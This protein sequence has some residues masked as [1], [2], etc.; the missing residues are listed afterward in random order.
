MID[1]T[2]Q[3]PT[4]QCGREATR[5]RYC[6]PCLQTELEWNK[7][8]QEDLEAAA[9]HHDRMVEKSREQRPAPTGTA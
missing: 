1:Q 2:R 6:E 8:P 4:C 7:A 5:G 3:K 9:R